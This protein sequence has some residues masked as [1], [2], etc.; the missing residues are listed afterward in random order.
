MKEQMSQV[1]AKYT[2]FWYDLMHIFYNDIMIW[3]LLTHYRSCGGE[4][5][6]GL[7]HKGSVMGGVNVP[8]S[9]KIWETKTPM[10]WRYIVH[11]G[12]IQIIYISTYLGNFLYCPKFDKCK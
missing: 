8:C 3:K 10:N 1:E 12:L 7:P 4:R 11:Q 6:D 5:I 9:L 2:A